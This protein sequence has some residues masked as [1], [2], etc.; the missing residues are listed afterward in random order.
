MFEMRKDSRS[1]VGWAFEAHH[2]RR[3]VDRR[4]YCSLYDMCAPVVVPCPERLYL[5]KSS[6]LFS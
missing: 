3:A 5:T 1:S 4:N 2:P 6:G